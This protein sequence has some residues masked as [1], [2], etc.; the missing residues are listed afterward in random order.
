MPRIHGEFLN[1]TGRKRLEAEIAE[2]WWGELGEKQQCWSWEKSI[3]SPRAKW[4]TWKIKA[5]DRAKCRQGCGDTR[6]PGGC[7]WRWK[8]V[9]L[10]CKSACVSRK[11]NTQL[12]DNQP[13]W[14]Y[15]NMAQIVMQLCVTSQIQ[16]QPTCPSTGGESNLWPHNKCY[17]AM[18]RGELRYMWLRLLFLSQC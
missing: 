3:V 6:S 5:S 8:M 1:P 16:T 7:R 15:R 10:S 9:Q 13:V 18:T 14:S 12:Y 17:L 11:L 2:R 4:L